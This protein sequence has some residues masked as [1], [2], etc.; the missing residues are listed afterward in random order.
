MVG[1]DNYKDENKSITIE[2]LKTTFQRVTFIHLEL[3][4]LLAYS[5]T[6]GWEY[7]NYTIGNFQ[8][9]KDSIESN[10]SI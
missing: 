9:S 7:K 3:I 6:F 5:Y 8:I 4:R 2:Y 1:M 10:P